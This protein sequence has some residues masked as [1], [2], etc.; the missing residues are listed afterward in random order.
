[1]DIDIKKSL[2]PTIGQIQMD[3]TQLDQVLVNLIMNG[4]TP[5]KMEGTSSLKRAVM[6]A[7]GQQRRAA[8]RPYVA[9]A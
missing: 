6:S 4:R 3:P 7:E 9:L 5:C 8:A 1:M 2:D